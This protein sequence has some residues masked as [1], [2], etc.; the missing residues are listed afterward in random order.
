MTPPHLC[1]SGQSQTVSQ[2]PEFCLH[3]IS[4]PAPVSADVCSSPTPHSK[5]ML[6]PH[7]SLDF[8]AQ[9]LGPQ[10]SI[11]GRMDLLPPSLP[12]SGDAL[13]LGQPQGSGQPRF[14]P[15]GPCFPP[16]QGTGLGPGALL[17]FAGIG[18]SR[19]MGW[20][21]LRLGGRGAGS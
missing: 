16:G 14:T 20:A 15:A 21:W 10:P 13:L 19:G 11:L 2:P 4:T 6:P 8:L 12:T 3:P 1:Y 18:R 7:P 17:I 9:H 5:Q